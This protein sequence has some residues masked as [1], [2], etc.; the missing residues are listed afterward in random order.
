MSASTCPLRG[1]PLPSQPGAATGGTRRPPAPWKASRVSLGFWGQC[2]GFSAPEQ[3]QWHIHSVV[4]WQ[5]E[6]VDCSWHRK[7]TQAYLEADPLHHLQNAWLQ[8][9]HWR[10]RGL[11]PETPEWRTRQA[12]LP[13]SLWSPPPLCAML[14]RPAEGALPMLFK[15]VSESCSNT[16]TDDQTGN[17]SAPHRQSRCNLASR[18]CMKPAVH[19]AA[20]S[21]KA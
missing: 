19:P 18:R 16:Q 2:H 15:R 4:S 7:E 12:P 9:H 11:P 14:T 6:L 10:V 20:G 17:T 13:G 8:Q 1:W 3:L 5:N 21:S